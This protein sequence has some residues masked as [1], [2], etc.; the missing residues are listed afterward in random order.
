MEEQAN[1]HQRVSVASDGSVR[2]DR[3]IFMQPERFSVNRFNHPTTVQIQKRF[4]TVFDSEEKHKTEIINWDKRNGTLERIKFL[5]TQRETNKPT[6]SF[7]NRLFHQSEVCNFGN[8]RED[9]VTDAIIYS[10]KNYQLQSSL[11]SAH[12][13]DLKDVINKCKNF[14]V[15]HFDN[16][17]NQFHGMPFARQYTKVKTEAKMDIKNKINL[18]ALF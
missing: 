3:E 2:T 8:R 12:H 16:Y 14:E 6:S 4:F 18:N 13:K 17:H 7:I 9:R 10:C 1:Y 5:N 15:L 11:I